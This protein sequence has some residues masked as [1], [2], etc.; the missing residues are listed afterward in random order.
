MHD[1][2]CHNQAS[3]RTIYCIFLHVWKSEVSLC[4]RAPSQIPAFVSKCHS[5]CLISVCFCLVPSLSFSLSGFD[6]TPSR[7]VKGPSPVSVHLFSLGLLESSRPVKTTSRSISL[8]LPAPWEL[9]NREIMLLL[10][11]LKH[12]LHL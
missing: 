12:Q 5:T 4:M 10:S 1:N 11:G 9:V 6:S 3:V 2:V 8:E 7:T